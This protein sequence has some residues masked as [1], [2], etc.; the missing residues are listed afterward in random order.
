MTLSI[1]F[2]LIAPYFNVS[3][4]LR[5]QLQSYQLNQLSHHTY[6]IIT[7]TFP[8]QETVEAFLSRKTIRDE[9]DIEGRTAFMWAAGKGADDVIKT[10]IK[11][12]VDMHHTDKNGGTGKKK[13]QSISTHRLYRFMVM[14]PECEVIFY[15]FYT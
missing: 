6:L 9:P 1:Q 12:G 15:H 4:D 3:I 10:F 7:L 14:S 8:R 5:E 11:H 2:S 13:L